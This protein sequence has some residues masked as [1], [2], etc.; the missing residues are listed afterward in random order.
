MT[1]VRELFFQ[2]Y[3]YVLVVEQTVLQGS[4]QPSAEDVRGRITSLLEQQ[5]AE[6]KRQGMLDQD[7]HD[8]RFAFIAW[9]DE[10]LLGLST[11]EYQRQWSTLPL[12][13]EYYETRNAGEELFERLN[14]LRA[15]QHDIREI[16]YLSLGL[17]F[18][19]R[20][21]L[22]MEDTLQL[23]RIRHEQV[24]HLPQ[25]VEELP[26]LDKL[27]PQPYQISAPPPLP[28]KPP[29]TALLLKAGIALLVM[30][31]L[32]VFV[33]Y[34]FIKPPPAPTV[35]LAMSIQ[36]NGKGTVQSTPAGIDCG[37]KCKHAFP[38]KT[39]VQFQATPAPG[40]VFE[41]WQG[42]SDCLDGKVTLDTSVTCQ[43]IFTLESPVTKVHEVI[44][45]HQETCMVLNVI[46]IQGDV[47]T[48]GGYIG[49]LQHRDTIR[50]ALLQIQGI[51]TVNDGNVRVLQWPLCEVVELL[52]PLQ[53]HAQAQQNGLALQLNKGET[54]TYFHGENLIA[55]VQTPRTST[56]YVYVDYYTADK[57]VGHLLPNTKER[58]NTFAP[59][60]MIQVGRLDGPQQW[61]ILPP[62]GLELV[63]VIASSTPLFA[64]ARLA[65]ESA[66][67]YLPAL[68]EALKRASSSGVVATYQFL[69]TQQ[70]R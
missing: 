45:S 16:Y 11:W 28:I 55:D 30:V 57:Y 61:L 18:S 69:T 62:F 15:D 52:T 49:S 32:L 23:N 68:R 60:S 56:S 24:Q 12:Q 22:G 54:P 43:A 19:G 3:A 17:G 14:R 44:A 5:E 20:Y 9:A 39:V 6:A 21:F 42:E 50:Q 59:S 63:T 41:R 46:G 33:V 58:A 70:R 26:T 51:S 47:V 65:P 66:Q 25:T 27:T 38:A 31:P 37:R 29:L 34:W 67:D 40:S 13:L 7:Y 35:Q 2:L 53:T 36:G 48:L 1:N 64:P 4:V 8:A 10:V